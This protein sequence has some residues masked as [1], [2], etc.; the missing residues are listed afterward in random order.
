MIILATNLAAAHVF[1][2]LDHEKRGR[3]CNETYRHV[4]LLVALLSA[5]AFFLL[6]LYS[7]QVLALLGPNFEGASPVL[8]ILAA[9]R[10]IRNGLGTSAFLL[11]LSGRQGVEMRNA[12]AGGAANIGLNLAL[13]PAF[14]VIGAA[15]GTTVAEI[16]LNLLR[17]WK[18]RRLM[19]V[20]VP[21]WLLARIALVGISV[22][23]MVHVLTPYLG[24]DL[25]RPTA[26][27]V[28]AA[29][30]GG[31]FG[32]ALWFLAVEHRDRTFLLKVFQ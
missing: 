32:I 12:A 25:T 3:E 22:A 27:L 18:I 29:A 7:E 16:A 24:V 30:A 14:G 17:T 9:G 20:A 8:I 10:L 19:D 1:P 2:V 15:I 4:T 5:P 26:F 21:W 31:V 23:L 6:T 11:V 13:I 28:N